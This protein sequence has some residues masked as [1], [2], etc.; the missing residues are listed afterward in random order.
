M[1]LARIMFL[2][3]CW[4]IVASAT[5]QETR[6]RNPKG[7]ENK[8]SYRKQETKKRL[9]IKK[10]HVEKCDMCLGCNKSIKVFAHAHKP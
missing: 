1:A 7:I 8:R 5:I 6:T 2:T 4:F 3:E 9:P 10:G